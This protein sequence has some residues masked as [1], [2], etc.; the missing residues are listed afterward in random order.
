[1]FIL[2]VLCDAAAATCSLPKKVG[3]RSIL[4]DCA[5]Q[6]C[7]RS[8]ESIATLL[9]TTRSR[10][11]VSVFPP[12]LIMSITQG[13][14]PALSYKVGTA[15]YRTIGA[16]LDEKNAA[17]CPGVWRGELHFGDCRLRRDGGQAVRCGS[18]W[19]AE[20]LLSSTEY[21]YVPNTE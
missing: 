10:C 8:L 9:R 11:G 17:H 6:D 2:L 12:C 19:R 13:S 7:A 5:G 3:L 15:Q 21:P 16:A 1:M 18:D 4:R 14:L 20:Q